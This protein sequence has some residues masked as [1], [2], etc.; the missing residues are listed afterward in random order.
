MA[1]KLKYNKEESKGITYWRFYVP[2]VF[3]FQ[4]SWAKIKDDNDKGWY[5][6]NGK[7]YY[8]RISKINKNAIIAFIGRLCVGIVTFQK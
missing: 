8:C 4:I 2:R 3:G 1:H 5:S 6:I 7:T